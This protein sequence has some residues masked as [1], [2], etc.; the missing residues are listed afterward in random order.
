MI[1]KIWLLFVVLLA[2]FIV[3]LLFFGLT[4]APVRE[5]YS[6]DRSNVPVSVLPEYTVDSQINRLI[7]RAKLDYFI[8]PVP[9][10][11]GTLIFKEARLAAPNDIYLIFMP[12]GEAENMIVYCCARESDRLLWKALWVR[13]P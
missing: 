12:K 8:A 3:A 2:V 6:Q 4:A 1:R 11:R 10:W 5:L 13:A 9:R 7:R